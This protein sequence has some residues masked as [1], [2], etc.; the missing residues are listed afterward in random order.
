MRVRV[1]SKFCAYLR[2]YRVSCF[3]QLGI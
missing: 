1:Y 2:Q 3:K